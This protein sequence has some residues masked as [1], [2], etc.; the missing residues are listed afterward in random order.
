VTLVHDGPGVHYADVRRVESAAEM[1]EAT[2]AATEGADAL[3]AAAA[4]GDYTV[5]RRPEKIRSGGTLTLELRPTA[6]VVDAVR[7]THPDLPV[8][9]FKAETA[10]D[11]AAMVEAARGLADRIGAA[12]V[13]ANDAS[14]MGERETRALLVRDDAAPEVVTG[15]KAALGDRVAR[16][17]A[18]VLG[19]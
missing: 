19:G 14:V 9:G 16:A 18:A 2:L 5:E 10:G 3:V 15:S 17:L 6:K 12:F 4:V 8:V 1:R 7:E 13:V 11:D